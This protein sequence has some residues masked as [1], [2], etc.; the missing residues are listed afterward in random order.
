M[1]LSLFGFI[2]WYLL[3]F[4]FT[5]YVLLFVELV[6]LCKQSPY[7]SYTFKEIDGYYFQILYGHFIDLFIL[8]GILNSNNVIK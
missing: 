8:D 1:Y 3:L 6:P 7:S 5:I 4:N 2:A